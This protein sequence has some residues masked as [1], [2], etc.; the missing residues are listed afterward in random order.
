MIFSWIH[1][2]STKSWFFFEYLN[3]AKLSSLIETYFIF[4][5]LS[6]FSFTT[7]LVDNH[8]A[9]YVS[10]KARFF[11]YIAL[12]LM[13]ID[14]IMWFFVEEEGEQLL[15]VSC[16]SSFYDATSLNSKISFL[17]IRLE[18]EKDL[19]TRFFSKKSVTIFF[20]AIHWSK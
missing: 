9:P 11:M 18:G 12:F 4:F 10:V 5:F 8:L 20:Y 3:S 16:S 13:K 7:I 17:K 19:H 6:E 2:S 14:T 15:V 1:L